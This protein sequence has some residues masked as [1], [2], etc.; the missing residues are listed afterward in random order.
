MKKLIITGIIA[1]AITGSNCK[2]LL[3]TKPQDFVTPETYFNKE[4]DATTALNAAYDMLTRQ[5][6]F[7]GYYQYRMVVADDVVCQLTGSF[8]GNLKIDASES[9]AIPLMWN[10]LY[11][12]IQYCNILLENLPRVTMDETRR[13][14][15]RGEALFLR[16]FCYSILVVNWGP[17]PM[18]T[19][20]TTGPT[21]VNIAG[22]S[23]K[24]IYDQILKDMTEAEALVPTTA[25]ALYGGAGYPAR[26]TV[27]AF[28]A[29]TCLSMAGE[30]L[31]DVSKY[32][33]A[34]NWA[35][36]VVD[37][38]EHALNPDYTDVFIRL[39]SGQFDKKEVLWE[40]D[41]NDI[42][43]S[44]EHGNIGYL[45]GIPNAAAVLGSSVGQV[46]IT[47]KLYNSYGTGTTIKDMR[48]D[49]NCSPFTWKSGASTGAES[50]KTYYTATQIYDRY[51]SKYRLNYTP[52]PR[53]TGRSPIN[54]PLMRYSD[55]LLMLAEADN[56]LNGGPTSLA[57]SCVNQVRERAWGKML[58]GATNP[59]EADLPTTYNKDSFLQE[60]QNERLRELPS[61]A[62]RKQDLLR[63]GIFVSTIKALGTDVNDPTQPAVPAG[64]AK[65]QIVNLATLVSN[66]DLLWPIPATELTYNKLLKQNTGW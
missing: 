34:K 41:F 55:V 15:I 60:I 22:S 66:R 25:S 23:V 61:E 53:V 49:W 58:A 2:K 65:T 40:V 47:R 19:K 63:W 54:F 44:T 4:S 13:G 14:V 10:N 38:K 8:P 29:R 51:D 31:K 42:T 48:R 59:A 18:R 24:D 45:N 43:G 33:D 11:T 20:P 17:V 12:T 37:S 16:A 27:Q 6:M 30:P 21:D 1:I 64:A 32:Q 9:A 35:Q 5:W 52:Q 3:D 57:Y 39:A 28:L 36:K 56:Y 26:T 62:I 50:E 46:R 7:S